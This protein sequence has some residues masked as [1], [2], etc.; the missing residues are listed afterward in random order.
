M[1]C[2]V[3]YEGAACGLSGVY[4]ALSCNYICWWWASLALRRRGAG[5]VFVA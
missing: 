1:A 5:G 2:V 3:V 4:L